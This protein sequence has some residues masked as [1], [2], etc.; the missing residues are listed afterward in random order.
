MCLTRCTAPRYSLSL[1]LSLSLNP[2]C[3]SH[4]VQHPGF[5]NKFLVRIGHPIATRFNNKS[6]LE[7]HH[8]QTG[9]R[10]VMQSGV[11][12]HFPK[13]DRQILRRLFIDLVLET[14]PSTNFDFA[15]RCVMLHK[16]VERTNWPSVQGAVSCFMEDRDAKHVAQT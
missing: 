9:W 8:A 3:A 13:R 2:Y 14:D 4:D 11:I 5:D 6:V 7:N 16:V 15:R 10:L 12:D 1:S